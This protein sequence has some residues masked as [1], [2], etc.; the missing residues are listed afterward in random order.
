MIKKSVWSLFLLSTTL[1]AQSDQKNWIP[2][3]PIKNTET[4]ISDANKSKRTSNSQMIQN[5]TTIK[6]L[7]DHVAKDTQ[8]D[9]AAKKWYQ[10]EPSTTD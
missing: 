2:I 4:S 3:H 7:L 6:N 9:D 8:E 5:L 10:L 1:L